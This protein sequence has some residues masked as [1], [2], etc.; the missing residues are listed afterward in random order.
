MNQTTSFGGCI[1]SFPV[2][3]CLHLK[4]LGVSEMANR[5]KEGNSFKDQNTRSHS[6]FCDDSERLENSI[7]IETLTDLSLE[8][9]AATLWI[10]KAHSNKL[11]FSPPHVYYL[12]EW[13]GWS[14]GKRLEARDGMTS[15]TH[16]CF[17]QMARCLAEIAI[18]TG[19]VANSGS[20]LAFPV[21]QSFTG[22]TI[23]YVLHFNDLRKRLSE[24]T[25]L[26]LL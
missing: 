23:S 25:S 11:S 4:W 6:K 8:H 3:A 24:L 12:Q 10:S 2:P 20:S 14:I 9:L 7:T 5:A 26:I 17:K 16:S 13:K 22:A 15:L 1:I 21:S 19:G 18:S